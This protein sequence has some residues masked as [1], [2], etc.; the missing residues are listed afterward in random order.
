MENDNL[1]LVTAE[2]IEK[3]CVQINDLSRKIGAHASHI[4]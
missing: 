4:I 3:Q 1:I 2:D